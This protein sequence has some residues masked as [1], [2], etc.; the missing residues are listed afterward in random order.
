MLS[1]AFQEDM[2]EQMFVFPVREGARLPDAFA[3]FAEIP[4]DALTIRPEEIEANRERWI[5]EWTEI[6]L[7]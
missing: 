7:R 5:R 3:K 2:P 1:K 6:V 4:S